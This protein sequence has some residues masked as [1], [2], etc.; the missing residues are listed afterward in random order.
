MAA[1]AILKI[2][3]WPLLINWLSDYV[4]ILYAETERHADKGH[5]IKLQVFEIQDGGRPPFSKSLNYHIP[6]K[7]LLDF[8]KIWCTTACIEPDE[9]FKSAIEES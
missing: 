2:V 9:V 1:A 6:V 4:E 3:F 5:M 8:D 7:I